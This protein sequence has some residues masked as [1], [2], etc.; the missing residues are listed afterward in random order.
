LTASVVILL[1]VWF[2]QA[3]GK[4]IGGI[5]VKPFDTIAECEAGKASLLASSES[6]PIKGIVGMTITCVPVDV[7]VQAPVTGD[8]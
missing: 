7:K 6:T 2:G 1:L 4:I 5:E 3:N 8:E